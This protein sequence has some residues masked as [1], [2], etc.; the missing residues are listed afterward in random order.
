MVT[1]TRR[2]EIDK[3]WVNTIMAVDAVANLLS[4]IDKYGLTSVAHFV[5]VEKYCIYNYYKL[6][7]DNY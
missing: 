6:F 4:V 1:N 2:D 3:Y 5:L 7:I